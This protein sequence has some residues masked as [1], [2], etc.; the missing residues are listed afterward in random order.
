MPLALSEAGAFR[1]VR[2][3]P[4]GYHLVFERG[5]KVHWMPGERVWC[6]SAVFAPIGMELEVMH[7]WQHW[8]DAEGWTDNNR[9]PFDVTGGRDGGFRGYTYK[10][11]VT[12]GPWR[13]IV[14]TAAGRE[15]G[16]VRFDV[17]EGP[18]VRP[19]AERV[20]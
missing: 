15:I 14:E 18:P 16:R 11:H 9:I 6:F 12:P 3:E 10:E 2:R 4:D 19:L 20:Y 5:R 8:T 1:D 17:V 7:R 13:V